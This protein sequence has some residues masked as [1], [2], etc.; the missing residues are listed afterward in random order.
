MTLGPEAAQARVVEHSGL[1]TL[2]QDFGRDRIA[3]LLLLSGVAAT[4]LGMREYAVIE[5]LP[6]QPALTLL[7]IAVIAFTL[8]S[9][10]RGVLKIDLATALTMIWGVALTVAVGVQVVV[11]AGL[12]SCAAMGLGWRLVPSEFPARALLALIAGMAII[13]GVLGWLLPFPLHGRGL[14]LGALLLILGLCWKSVGEALQSMRSQWSDIASDASAPFTVLIV[15]VVG[16]AAWLPTTLFDDLVYH[17]ALPTQLM[18]LG[19]YR[20]DPASQLWALAPWASDLIHAIPTVLA[21]D[22]ARGAMNQIWL[23]SCAV[24]IGTLGCSLGLNR[25]LAWLAA[26]LFASL[27]LNQSLTLG[28]QTELPSTVAV[29]GLALVILHAPQVPDRR[30]LVLVAILSAFLMA[31]KTSNALTVLVFGIWLIARWRGQLPWPQ[32]PRALAIGLLLGGSSYFFAGWI[33]GNPVLP[34]YNDLFLSEYARPERFR[35]SRWDEPVDWDLF[36]SMTFKVGEYYSGRAGATGFVLVTLVGGALMALFNMKL[37]SFT[38]AALGIIVL[39]LLFAPYM[40][41]AFPGIALLTPALVAGMAPVRPKRWLELV[42]VGLIAIQ[43]A[44]APNSSHALRDSALERRIV[45]GEKSVLERHAPE[46]LIAQWILDSR[47]TSARIFLQ[48][49]TRPYTAPFAG[50]AFSWTWYDRELQE[51]IRG[52]VNQD[53]AADWKKF[54]AEYGITHVLVYGTSTDAVG[55]ALKDAELVQS[56]GRAELW[57]LP[58]EPTRDLAA[59]RDFARLM[60]PGG[61]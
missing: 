23:G 13:A 19:Y 14:Y 16:T 28:M 49:P 15:G 35:D 54:W 45:H 58:G 31:L 8:A 52:S 1:I 56:V 36:W 40:R 39:P 7:L 21:R 41:Y 51:Q 37:R 20:L 48:D 53:I 55:E 17:L 42:I 43:I 3:A 27:P 5:E 50:Q 47:Q 26:A 25:G 46:R 22:D 4:W 10:I 32:V 61:S 11:A 6:L 60:H 29:L 34:L 9:L 2:L 59:E 30:T 38:L 12:L 33:A 24:L 18:H 44:M 57:L